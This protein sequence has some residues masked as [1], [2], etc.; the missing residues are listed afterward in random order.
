MS[1]SGLQRAR[2]SRGALSAGLI[3]LAAVTLL[4][5]GLTLYVREEILDTSAFAGRA[6]DAIRQPAVRAVASREIAVQLVEPGV[7]DL[8]A[9]RPAIES[10][11]GVAISSGLLRPVVRLAAEHAH[12]LLFERGGNAVFDLADAGTVVVSALH[13]LSPSIAKKIPSR[14]EAVLLTVRRRSFAGSTLGFAETVRVLGL[15]LPVVGAALFVLAVAVAP[16]RRRA[17]TR[18]GVAIGVVGLGC[19]IALEIV[20]R[21]IV[22]HVYGA[23]ELTN[24]DVRAAAGGVWGAYVDDLMMWLIAGAAA[25]WLLAAGAAPLLRPYS[26]AR[27]LARVRALV[28]RTELAPRGRVVRGALVFA[29]GVWVIVDPSLALRVAAVAF[30]AILLYVASGELLSATAP[31]DGGRARL[32]LRAPRRLAAAAAGVAAIAAGIGVAVALTGGASNVKAGT[33]PTCNGYA[34]LC[35]RRLDEVVFAGTHNSMSAAD[36][37]GWLIANQDRTIGRQLQDGI[38]LFKISTHSAIADSGGG[39]HT[40]IT[41]E[42]VNVNRV[43]KKLGPSARAALERLSRA[44]GRGSLANARRDIWLCHTLCELGATRMVAF[45]SV[46]RRFIERNP[47]QVVIL[48]D[49]DYVSERD[50]EGAFKR[51]GLFRYL[52]ALNVREP[53]PTLAQLI[54]A[55]HNV[56]VFSQTPASDRYRWNADGFTWI[57]DTPLGARKPDQFTCKPSR[58]RTSNPLLMMNDWADVFPPRPQPNVPLLTR[59]FILG[60]AAQCVSERG[61]VPNLILTDYYNRGDVVGAVAELNDVAGQDPAPTVAVGN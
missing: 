30:G 29:A 47:G 36:S 32:R 27:G 53:L 19:A 21:Y 46:I 37:P 2:R 7:P 34:Q 16:S 50:L 35:D 25:G 42:R 57:Q 20:R 4:A 15:V 8:V 5:G 55:H 33:I 49:E 44:L 23:E 43:A 11:V 45:L 54:R 13:T 59:A 18:S 52:A 39:V 51:A 48:F 24:A 9:A 14:S 28:L 58:G 26:A 41:A 6:V 61:K 17:I 40:D 3:V 12:R 1:S 22:G 56:V 38:R 60:R 31:A 10:A